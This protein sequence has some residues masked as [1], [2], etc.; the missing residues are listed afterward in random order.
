MRTLFATLA[1]ATLT[2]ATA[3]EATAQEYRYEPGIVSL[4]IGLGDPTA[5]DLKIW[6]T[7]SSGIDLGIGL[8][9]FDDVLGLYGEY[10]FG[11]A[12]FR[13][14]QSGGRGVVYIGLG[15][16]VA[17]TAEHTTVAL[18]IPI[19]V[20]FRFRPPVDLYVEARPGVGLVH[21]PAFGIGGQVGVRFRFR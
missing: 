16:A 3:S 21:R 1:L 5:L 12:D 8:E 2:F 19:G 18:I 20:D 11:L 7:N 15:G 6:T 10:E 9:R 17:F 13:L 4:G 14:G